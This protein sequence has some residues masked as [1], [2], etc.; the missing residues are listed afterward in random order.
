MKKKDP[1]NFAKA[2]KVKPLKL[3]KPPKMHLHLGPHAGKPG[4]KGVGGAF[5]LT[6]KASKK[7]HAFPKITFN[8]F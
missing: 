1:F 8:E 4:G 2:P 7:K 5:P 3:A 6:S